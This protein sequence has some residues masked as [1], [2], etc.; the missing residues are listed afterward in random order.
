MP[1]SHLQIRKQ[2]KLPWISHQKVLHTGK[3]THR[4]FLLFSSST[5]I[6]IL[7]VTFFRDPQDRTGAEPMDKFMFL[8]E[9]N[10]SFIDIL[11]IRITIIW[12]GI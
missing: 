2:R 10:V 3:L 8:G 12:N 7:I 1:E 6:T 4:F 11:E 5:E 9:W